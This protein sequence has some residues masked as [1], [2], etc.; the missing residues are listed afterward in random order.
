[1]LLEAVRNQGEC[2][3]IHMATATKI[4]FWIKKNRPADAQR[5]TRR[6]R[7]KLAGVDCWVLSPEDTILAKLEWS[8]LAPSDRQTQDIAGIIEIQSG[9]LDLGYLREWADELRV[10][11]PLVALLAAR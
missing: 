8:A 10:R 11:Q 3:A 2:N 9:R 5:F 7:E 6:R 4:D 1:M